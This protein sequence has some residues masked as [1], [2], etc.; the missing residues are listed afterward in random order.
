MCS[1]RQNVQGA[2]I[3]A[4]RYVYRRATRA[5]V[6]GEAVG[7]YRLKLPSWAMLY[8]VTVP[9]PALVVYA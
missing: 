4:K 1:T 6:P 2:T 8:P 3:A 7:V 9:L 5:R